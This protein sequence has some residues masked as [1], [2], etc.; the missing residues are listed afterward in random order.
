MKK[1]IAVLALLALVP[2]FSP[3]N[4]DALTLGQRVNKLEAKLSCLLRLPM[5]EYTDFAGYGDPADGPNATDSYATS[6]N[7]TADPNAIDNP[8]G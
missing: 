2:V 8:D 3:A 6:A 5:N 1:L 7:T 4:A